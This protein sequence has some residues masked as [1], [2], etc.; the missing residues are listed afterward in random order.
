MDQRTH[1]RQDRDPPVP[2]AASG[3]VCPPIAPIG[4]RRWWSEEAPL[5]GETQRTQTTLE[6]SL[7]RYADLFDL[8]PVGYLILT[9][10]GLI[11]EANRAAIA[12]LGVPRGALPERPLACFI[13]PEDESIFYICRQNLF[14]M[15]KRQACELRLRQ[16]DGDPA[17]VRLEM[18]LETARETGERHCLTVLHDIRAHKRDEMAW[19]AE[20]EHKDRF[21]ALLAY[22]LRNPLAPLRQLAEILL[23]TPT[24]DTARIQQTAQTISR[25]VG[26][27]ARLADDLLD[28]TRIR[29]GKI[30]LAKR[31]CDLREVVESAADQARPLLDQR[32]Q[33]LDMRLPSVPVRLHGDA[34]RLVQAIVHLLRNVS[35]CSPP[36]TPVTVTLNATPGMAQLLVEDQ[37]SGLALPLAHPFNAVALASQTQASADGR[38]GLGLSLAKGLVELHGGHVKAIRPGPAQGSTC[39]VC[40]PL[41]DAPLMNDPPTLAMVSGVI[42]RILV[43]E[44]APNVA[45]ACV[46][47][48][49]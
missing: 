18:T 32:Q 15:G 21:L 9:E 7:T 33:R 46:Q 1:K 23:G 37:G 28:V 36:G 42:R 25:Q 26:H 43:V 5:N 2:S 12:L 31:M 30:P 8:A 3:D 11:R 41:L 19:R 45:D 39:C 14:A 4:Y 17:W 35:Q 47:T 24:G 13:L 49:Y 40:L 38:L 6:G 29:H 10:R 48:G 27:L 44:D 22:E 16:E 20:A 34:V